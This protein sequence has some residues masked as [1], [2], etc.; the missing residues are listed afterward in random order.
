MAMNGAAMMIGY[1][2]MG[3]LTLQGIPFQISTTKPRV[4]RCAPLITNA[5]ELHGVE[6]TAT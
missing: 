3:T 6:T 2:M 5:L 1:D 4:N